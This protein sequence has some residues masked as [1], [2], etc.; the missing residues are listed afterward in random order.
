MDIE[1]AEVPILENLLDTGLIERIDW[2]FAETHQIVIPELADRTMAL[3]QR[4]LQEG[5]RNISLDW[6]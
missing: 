3:R 4:V 1:G 2:V 5:W 6:V